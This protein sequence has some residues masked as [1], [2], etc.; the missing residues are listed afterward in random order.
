MNRP[1]DPI[2]PGGPNAEALLAA[3]VA[4][5]DDAIISKD[6]AGIV[7]S[8][9]QGAT[10]LF[11]YTAAEMIGRSITAL[12]PPDRQ[13]EERPLSHGI[14]KAAGK[15]SLPGGSREKGN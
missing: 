15:I 4:S 10:A 8:W 7:T 2:F 9:N 14:E 5:S 6:T 1:T 3:I 12:I 13:A 11:G